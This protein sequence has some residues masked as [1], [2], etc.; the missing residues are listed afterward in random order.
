VELARQQVTP[1]AQDITTDDNTY[2]TIDDDIVESPTAA[3]LSA[4][5][6][7]LTPY[8]QATARR[9]LSVTDTE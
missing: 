3:N 5:T 8:F 7:Q 1:A 2:F 6:G 4:N 9:L